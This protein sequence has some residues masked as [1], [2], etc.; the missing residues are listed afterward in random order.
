MEMAFEITVALEL[1]VVLKIPAT[2][3]MTMNPRGGAG[4]KA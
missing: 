1:A 2:L 3:E 4:G